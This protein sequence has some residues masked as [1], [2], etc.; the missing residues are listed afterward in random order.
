MG[1]GLI[2][3]V[4]EAV[5]LA[6]IVRI[7]QLADEVGGAD[8]PGSVGNIGRV[9]SVGHGK[10]GKLQPGDHFTGVEHIQMAEALTHENFAALHMIR[11]QA[12][13][14]GAARWHEGAHGLV[15]HIGA[16]T[17]G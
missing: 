3:F 17:I 15:D 14:R 9:Q 11:R 6:H 5:D 10:A 16:V 13:I 7:A 2:K 4:I 12:G 8:Q 1:A